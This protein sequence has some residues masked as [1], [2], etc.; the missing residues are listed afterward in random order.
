MKQTWPAPERN[1]TAILE[2]LTATLPESGGVLLEVAAG[3]G[4]HAVH[5]ARELPSWHILPSDFDEENLVSVRAWVDGEG[6]DN[7]RQP[8]SIDVTHQTWPVEAVDAVFNANMIHIAPWAATLGLLDGVARLLQPGNPL[9]MYGPYKRGGLH[10]APSNASFDENL[11][12]RNPQ[13]GVRD[14][15]VVEDAARARG[16]RLEEVI[17]MPANNLCVIYRRTEDS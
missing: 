9:I 11:K 15:D 17:E 1:K 8:V 2:V 3:S 10:T 5:F 7:L 16:L 6:L 14:L 4:Q 13:W 12:G